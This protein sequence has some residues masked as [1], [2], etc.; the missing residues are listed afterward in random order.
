MTW[1][2]EAGTHWGWSSC[3][4]AISMLLAFWGAVIAAL[5]LAGCKKEEEADENA[6]DKG[7]EGGKCLHGGCPVPVRAAIPASD[8]GWRGANIPFRCTI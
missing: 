2:N 6:A 1:W 5:A 3:L 4:L 7:A 8:A